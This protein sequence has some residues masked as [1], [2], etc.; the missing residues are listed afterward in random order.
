MTEYS[1]WLDIRGDT[2]RNTQYTDF[3]GGIK[4]DL[5]FLEYSVRVNFTSAENLALFQTRFTL[6]NARVARTQFNTTYDDGTI[7]AIRGSAQLVPFRDFTVTGSF[8]Q[9]IY[10]M[11]NEAKAWGLPSTE[12]N[13][14]LVYTLFDQQ[15]ALKSNLYIADDIPF[16]DQN[17]NETTTNALFDLNVGAH[18]YF[19]EN[20]G[21]FVEFNNILNN[22]RERWLNYP[23]FGTNFIAGVQARF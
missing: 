17:G 23:M 21:A 13:F 5:G 2:I 16:L 10:D 3:F 19:I 6:D 14:G 1:P 15:L 8:S 12:G 18:Y 4:G 20:I 22:K 9:N 7:Y 11:S